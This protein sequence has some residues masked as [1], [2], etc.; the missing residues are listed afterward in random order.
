MENDNCFSIYTRII[1]PNDEILCNNC[2]IFINFIKNFNKDYLEIINTPKYKSIF[3][4][5]NK[6]EMFKKDNNLYYIT[7]YLYYEDYN[8]KK[9]LNTKLN[10]ICK[11]K[12]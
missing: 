5:I 8:F 1:N 2:Y 4:K 3:N 11:N 6:I 10:I 9:E 7:L 12:K